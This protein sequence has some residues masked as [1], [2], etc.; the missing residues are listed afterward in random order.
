MPEP[1]PEALRHGS[2]VKPGMTV[3]LDSEPATAAAM[4]A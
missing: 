1:R 2:R 4:A 3:R